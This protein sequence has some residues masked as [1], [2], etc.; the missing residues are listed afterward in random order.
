MRIAL[1]QINPT[2]GDLG[3]NAARMVDAACQAAEQGARL[4]VFP[5]LSLCGYPPRDLLDLP[6]FIADARAWLQRLAQQLP[7]DLSVIAGC[8]APAPSGA[9]RPVYNAAALIR[10]GSVEA[11]AQKRL[12][13]TYD[14]FD[15]ERYFEPGQGATVVEIDGLR[16]G[17]TVCED[18]WNDVDTPFRRRYAENPVADCV[19]AGADAVVNIAASPFTL[20]KRE[21]RPRMLAGVAAHH[22][23]PLLFVNQ[24]GGNDELVFDGSSAL[25]GPDGSTWARAQAFEEDILV[26]E[27]GPGGRLAREC[28]NDEEAALSALGLGVRDYAHKCGFT[29]AVLGLSGGIDSSLVA[30]IAAR[31][32]GPGKVLAVAMPTRYSSEGSL[33]DAEE[34]AASLGIGLRTVPIDAIFQRYLEEL[35][36]ALEALGPAPDQDTTFENLQA[37]IRGAVLMGIANRFGLLV[38]NTGNKS[39]GAAGYC[40]LYGDAVGALAVIGDLSK[41]L[42]Y[43]VG[44][45]V[46]R[47]A[48]RPVIPESV[49][50]KA[51]SAELRPDQ[52]DQD[53]L[54]PY[55]LLDAVLQRLVES[56]EST[57]EIVAEGFDES[58]VKQVAR[59]IF[60]SEHKR[61]QMPP[62]LIV[63]EKAFGP[64]R[65]YPIAQRYRG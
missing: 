56:R 2:V 42:V 20:R 43:R 55:E 34:L 51:P 26:C 24:V 18:A 16:L 41:T 65:R 23:R 36:P 32:L 38:L 40:T 53:S 61:R 10:A 31:A 3:G 8:L 45:E 52:T 57:A 5:E 27:L 29:R 59:L 39:E 4:A 54:P 44:R 17:I 37:R 13:P 19:A 6:G 12:L 9:R 15:E 62:A 28:E 50:S 30:C 48:G 25:F 33:R 58:V 14:V 7:P 11:V 60:Q 35:G 21:Q 47:Q 49:F 64:G 1:L 46:N 63:T 22:R